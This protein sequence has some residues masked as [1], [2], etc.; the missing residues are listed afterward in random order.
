MSAG[1]T[2]VTGIGEL[3]TCDGTG[4][5]GAGVRRDHALVVEDG[6]VAWVGP[7]A[8]APSA[9]AVVDVE[10]RCVLPGFVDS[11]AHLV[12]AGDRSAEF[13]ARMAGERYDGGGIGVSVGATRAAGDDELRALLAGRVAEMRAQGTTTVE[14]KS[15]YGL[16]VVDEVRALRLA[17]EV[18]PETTYLGAHVVP[19]E[20]RAD[21]SAYVDLVTGE[22]LAACAPYARWVD[23]FCEPAS[24]HAFTGEE[25]R[26]VLVAGRDAGLGLRVH[27]N[28]LGH[29][30]GVQLAC[31]LG[32][33]SVD[34]CTYLSTA[35]VDALV[36]GAG[37]TTATLLPG[38]EFS[39]RSPYPDARA[40]LDAGVSVA[41][42]SDCNPGTCFS[43]SMPFVVALAVRE[44]GMTPSEAVVA[45]TRGGASALRRAD[46]GRVEVGARADLAV[47]DA[48]NHLHLSY[49]AG[50][51][52]ARVLEV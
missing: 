6:R 52:I 9:D 31:E 40:L 14:V 37:T 21:R 35:D 34:H 50:V 19:E 42:A 25:S 17:G 15:G 16:T 39:T 1:S 24:P 29:G 30:P 36:D 23:V 7:A 20:M 51:P 18:T 22:M 43:S 5:G 48:P 49:R 26:A 33:A 3:V 41:L 47:L 11:H 32:A 13:A 4:D 45:A 28:Q 12:F 46:I 27:G 44:M 2:L 8:S 10:G 38:V